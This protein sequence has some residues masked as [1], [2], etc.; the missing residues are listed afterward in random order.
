MYFKVFYLKIGW[1]TARG[2]WWKYSN[3]RSVSIANG[4]AE[5]QPE[6]WLSIVLKRKHLISTWSHP[7][8]TNTN[9]K[10]WERR[11]R[12]FPSTT[13]I[14]GWEQPSNRRE[15][16]ADRDTRCGKSVWAANCHQFRHQLSRLLP[17]QWP[18]WRPK[19]GAG[20]PASVPEIRPYTKRQGP[21]LR[22][23]AGRRYRKKRHRQPIRP[24]APIRPDRTVPSSTT[25]WL[26]IVFA[27]SNWF[28]LRHRFC[29]DP[30]WGWRCARGGRHR[31]RLFRRT[32]GRS[33][34]ARRPSGSCR[35]AVGRD[36]CSFRY[37]SR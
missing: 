2:R 8:L 12:P 18:M 35:R 17:L 36:T 31:W 29:R 13:R 16:H 19:S 24:M 25:G 27:S 21:A 33:S 6:L 5:E 3:D 30:R 22:C 10:E 37:A 32:C 15:W 34:K 1:R 23:P 7:D 20:G 11:R 9:S 14:Q 28:Q 26:A 4:W